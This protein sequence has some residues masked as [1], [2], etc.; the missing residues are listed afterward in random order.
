[1]S[2]LFVFA[3]LTLESILI[4]AQQAGAH[5]EHRMG[6]LDHLHARVSGPGKLK[7]RRQSHDAQEPTQGEEIRRWDDE[8]GVFLH[9]I[10]E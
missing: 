1:M 5:G 4:S 3:M 7:N 2:E 9:D 10:A 6:A 8:R